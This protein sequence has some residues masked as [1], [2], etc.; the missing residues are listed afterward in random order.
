MVGQIREERVRKSSS[1]KTQK[2]GQ[3]R[4]VK[5]IREDRRSTE[6]EK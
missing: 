2:V 4:I 1:N 6:E 3:V 5:G